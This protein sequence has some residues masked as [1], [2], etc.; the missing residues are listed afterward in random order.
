MS[1]GFSRQ[2]YWSGLPCPP[3]G[4]FPDSGI[5]PEF[6]MSPALQADSLPLAPP[7]KPDLKDTEVNKKHQA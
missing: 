2:E 6:L 5:E 3:P 7:R 4:D 1:K